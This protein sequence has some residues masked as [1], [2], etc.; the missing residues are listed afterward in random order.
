MFLFSITYIIEY[1]VLIKKKYMVIEHLKIMFWGI[2]I[3]L[4]FCILPHLRISINII[5]FF[6]TIKN[7]FNE[8]KWSYN[9][10]MI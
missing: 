9:R 10:H 8:I 6:Y 5:K 3:I 1:I 2:I 7:I 4:S